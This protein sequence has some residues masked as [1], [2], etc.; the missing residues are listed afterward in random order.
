MRDTRTMQEKL[1]AAE[2]EIERLRGS[3]AMLTRAWYAARK[4]RDEALA[5]AELER[6][7][8]EPEETLAGV[9]VKNLYKSVGE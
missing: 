3:N 1:A 5:E 8:E 4:L 6:L 9:P 2:A 7:R